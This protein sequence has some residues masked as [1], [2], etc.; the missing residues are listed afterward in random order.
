MEQKKNSNQGASDRTRPIGTAILSYG[1]SGQV[2]HG[3]LLEADPAFRVEAVW[4][5]S[6]SRSAGRHPRARIVRHLQDILHDPDISLV[7]VN[8]P[9]DTH[10]TYTRLALEAGKHVVVEKPFTLTFRE[11]GELISLAEEKDLLLT[12]FQNRRWDGDFLTVRKL[13]EEGA[14]GRL[15]EYEAHFDRFRP[16][17]AEG[18][19]KEEPGRGTGNLYNLGTHLIDQCLLL[20]GMPLSVS[21]D[22][23]IQRPGARVHDYFDLR[24]DYGPHIAILRSSYLAAEPGPRFVI[25][26]TEG[27][28][29]KRGADPQEEALREGAIPGGSSWGEEDPAN[30]GKLFRVQQGQQPEVRTIPTERGDYPA[31]YRI[32]ARAIREGEPL[33]VDP[34]EAAAGIRIVE[35]CLESHRKG[36]KVETG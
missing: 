13:L 1:M 36:R 27:A 23:R 4:E 30:D 5:R 24:L 3:P 33:P 10:A 34:R 6:T 19:W 28:Y 18:S 21:A 12:V 8:T 22:L 31:F 15:V 11:A 7:V 9:D 32:L 35:A 26:G 20:F 2:F 17:V 29:V 14:P 16:A 25:R